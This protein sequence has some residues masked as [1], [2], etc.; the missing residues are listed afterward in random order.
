M[1]YVNRP[2]EFSQKKNSQTVSD[3][4]E[5]FVCERARALLS[6]RIKKRTGKPV[7]MGISGHYFLICREEAT[8]EYRSLLADRLEQ[9]TVKISPLSSRVMMVEVSFSAMM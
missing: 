1:E 7:R 2:S 6:R 5:P 9:V 8:K 4:T 3:P